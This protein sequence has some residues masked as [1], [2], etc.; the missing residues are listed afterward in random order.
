MAP[1]RCS[2]QGNVKSLVA[3]GRAVNISIHE[4]RFMS[5]DVSNSFYCINDV[6]VQNMLNQKLHCSQS[7]KRLLTHA[8]KLIMSHRSR[9]H[10]FTR[11]AEFRAEPGDFGFLPRNLNRGNIPRDFIFPRT[12]PRNLTFFIRTTIFSQKMTSK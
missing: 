3:S 10:S 5:S 2:W 7:Y 6:K 4:Q 9:A 12:I 11:T 8:I 1:A